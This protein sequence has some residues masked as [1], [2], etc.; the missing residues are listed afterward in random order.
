MRAGAYLTFGQALLG[1][2]LGVRLGALAGGHRRTFLSAEKGQTK[3]QSNI[4]SRNKSNYFE[5]LTQKFDLFRV[6][7]C[8][9]VSFWGLIPLQSAKF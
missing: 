5:N 8:G 7:A 9:L 4:V 1:R 2:D 3:K 6:L